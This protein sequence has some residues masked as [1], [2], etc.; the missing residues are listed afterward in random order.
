VAQGATEDTIRLEVLIVFVSIVIATRNRSVLLAQ[1]LEALAAQRWPADRLEIVI[2]DNGSTDDTR[3]VVERAARRAGGAPV[4]YLFVAQPGKSHAV[5]AAL[6]LTR[7]DLIAFTDD[8]VRP[9]PEWISALAR[10]VEDTDADFVAGRIQPI[11]EIEPPR[12]MSPA[13][14]GVLA[15]PDNGPERLPITADHPA[16]VMPIGANMAVRAAVIVW[17]GS[18]R[19]DLGKLAGSLRTGEDHEFFLRLL[20]AGCRGVYEPTALVAH[21]VPAERLTRR[22]FRRWLYQNGQDVARLE[23]A[24]PASVPFLFGVPRYLW[25]QVMVDAHSMIHAAIGRDD[26]RRFASALRVLWFL[27]YL[28]ESWLRMSSSSPDAVRFA[29]D[30]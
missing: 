12:W 21:V 4:R 16:R 1:T 24:Y 26:A 6:P 3:A 28:R 17:L 22:Y 15:I 2:S 14:Y 5:N 18:L 27:G 9:D 7:G 8:D 13:L 10:A 11:W 25:R 19:T 30:A 29:E 20:H 23:R